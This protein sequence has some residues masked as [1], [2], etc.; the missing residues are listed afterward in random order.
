METLEKN[1]AQS[2]RDMQSHGNERVLISVV[3]PCYNSDQ[4]LREL[5]ERVS[6]TFSECVKEPYEVLLIDDGSPS[7]VTWRIIRDLAQQFK[8]V[9][10]IRLTRNFGKP[11]AAMCGY[12]HAAGDWTILMDDDLQHAPEDIP[13]LL[14]KREH[15]LVMG[16]FGNRRHVFWQRWA[17]NFKSWLEGKLIGKPRDVTLSPF[18][19]IRRDILDAILNIRT[20]APHVGALMMYLTRDVVMVDVQHHARKYGVTSYSFRARVRQFSNLVINN[21]SLLLSLVARIG[22]L[23]AVLSFVLV[24]Y[25]SYR[26]LFLGGVV[27]GWTSLMVVTLFIGGLMLLAL[28]IVGEYLLR[29]IKGIE[30]RPP[31]VVAQSISKERPPDTE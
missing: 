26:K 3:I 1:A 28:G 2:I 15:D 29:I 16:R 17:S 9:R 14:D 22:F 5:V 25:L 21:S 13:K 8:E 20:P 19:M 7:E 23:L 6:S 4:S 24:G 18:H 27:E 31:F 10:G 11:G 30:Y 12:S